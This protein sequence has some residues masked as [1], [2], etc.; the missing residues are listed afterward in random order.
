[1]FGSENKAVGVFVLLLGELLE[2]LDTHSR[3]DDVVIGLARVAGVGIE[4]DRFGKSSG[5]DTI[6]NQHDAGFFLSYQLDLVFAGLRP[7]FELLVRD[8]KAPVS[9]PGPVLPHAM[10]AMRTRSIG[11]G[12]DVFGKFR[13]RHRSGKTLGKCRHAER[14]RCCIEQEFPAATNFSLLDAP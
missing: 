13:P 10:I 11:T 4:D 2:D 1:M 12:V 5:N 14:M 7:F 8:A 9:F 6:G 3:T